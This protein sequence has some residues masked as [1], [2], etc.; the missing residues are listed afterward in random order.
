MV[1]ILN[2]SIIYV[3]DHNHQEYNTTIVDEK[4]RRDDYETRRIEEATIRMMVLLQEKQDDEEAMI[5]GN[6]K[7]KVLQFLIS[8]LN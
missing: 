1:E 2:Y 8:H 3:P 7:H 4:E 5:L 6:I